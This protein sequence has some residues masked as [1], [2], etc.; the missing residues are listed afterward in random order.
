M[1]T[2]IPPPVIDIIVA[3]VFT[4]MIPSLLSTSGEKTGGVLYDWKID[5]DEFADN[6]HAPPSYIEKRLR[7]TSR[8]WS[9]IRKNVCLSL[10]FLEKNWTIEMMTILSNPG[11]PESFFRNHS[12]KIWRELPN[13]PNVSDDFIMEN[14]EKYVKH[15]FGMNWKE[16]KEAPSMKISGGI[17]EKYRI[18]D[19]ILIAW[20]DHIPWNA[21]CGRKTVSLNVLR[22]LAE[23]DR[24]GSG[25]KMYLG[26]R[27]WKRLSANIHVPIEFL[28]ENEDK[29]DVSSVLIHRN[30]PLGFVE[31]KCKK[32][33]DD[34]VTK[35][36]SLPLEVYKKYIDNKSDKEKYICVMEK[37][38]RSSHVTYEIL[39]TNWEI[40][41][42]VCVGYGFD[43][44]MYGYR[45]ILCQN[46]HTPMKFL[47]ENPN[48]IL[49]EYLSSNPS[50]PVHMVMKNLKLVDWKKLS[51]NS[52]FW[53]R[54][55]ETELRETL[56]EI[57]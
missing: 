28:M 41:K 16:C 48:L 36:S 43:D 26:V 3:Y 12:P 49:W 34:L 44:S 18:P 5:L 54:L 17:I 15:L 45:I 21:Y 2:R 25:K 53:K 40:I 6:P 10:E 30:V 11:V 35:I 1:T 52:E 55:I 33:A 7:S 20:K 37:V 47:E 23:A 9:F 29:V 24:K 38:F 13:N 19:A 32:Q 8:R 50:V 39:E 14:V 27:E 56:L 31:R 57:L 51:G 22:H 42:S 46:P 4:D